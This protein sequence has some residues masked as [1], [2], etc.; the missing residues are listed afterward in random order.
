VIASSSACRLGVA[1]LLATLGCEKKPPSLVV[2]R[3]LLSLPPQYDDR[4]ADRDSLREQVASRVADTAQLK[5][6]ANDRQATHLVTVASAEILQLPGDGDELRPV[7]VT[8]QAM[9]GGAEFSAVGRGLPLVDIVASTLTGFDDAW[10]VIA[11]E[12]R[13]RIAED[14]PVIAALGHPDRRLREFAIEELG[15]RRSRAAVEPLCKLLASEAEPELV[16]RSVGALVAI[17]DP[18]AAEPLIELARNRSP[19]VVIQIAYALGALGGS[20]AEGY[21]VTLA[22][23][24]PL[25]AVREAAERALKDLAARKRAPAAK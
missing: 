21:L 24:H 2:G 15:D 25:D 13:L 8:L 7:K 10:K 1:L 11:E 23:G 18:R 17:A 16:L 12:R 6:S 5:Y 4:A 19:E 14:A 22:S 3:V 9:K 20:V